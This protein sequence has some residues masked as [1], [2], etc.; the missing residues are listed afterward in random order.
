MGSGGGR[1]GMNRLSPGIFTTARRSRRCR[2]E[3]RPRRSVKDG[4]STM[5]DRCT[6]ADENHTN[7]HN[8]TDITRE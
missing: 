4:R 5:G 7:F 8:G 6:L 1:V 2:R 3:W